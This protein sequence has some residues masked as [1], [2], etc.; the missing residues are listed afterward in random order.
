MKTSLKRHLSRVP[1]PGDILLL[2]S[3]M[4]VLTNAGRDL[5]LIEV[6]KHKSKLF[7]FL[8]RACNTSGDET[9]VLLSQNGDVF[10]KQCQV[11]ELP[12]YFT[13]KVGSR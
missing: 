11:E 6:D 3:N 5:E 7:I 8:H 12:W 13:I 1:K 2:L 4:A 10:I 9:V